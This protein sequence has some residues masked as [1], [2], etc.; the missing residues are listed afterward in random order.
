MNEDLKKLQGTWAMVSMEMDGARMPSSMVAGARIV[1]N[2]ET[3]ASLGMGAVYKGTMAI[4][5]TKSPRTL[6]M[7]FT[8]GPERG[9]TSLAIYEVDGNSWKLCLGL[10]GKERPTGFSTAPGSGHVLETLERELGGEGP[11]QKEPG[12]PGDEPLPRTASAL[13][14]ADDKEDMDRFEGE[15]SGVSLVLN[16]QVL[17]ADFVKSFRRVVKGNETTVLNGGQV[18]LKATYTVDASKSPRTIDYQITLGPDKGKM[19]L[20]IYEFEG[21]TVKVCLSQPG[22]DRPT[23]F[24]SK[25]GDGRTFGVWK[26]PR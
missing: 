25:A 18:I 24:A 1:I 2:G 26:K 10:T 5:T 14:A 8:E 12:R 7:T 19:Q 22:S 13:P 16:G 17:P 9:N 20:G 23:E 21:E 3:F 15:W 6:D 11:A 4:D